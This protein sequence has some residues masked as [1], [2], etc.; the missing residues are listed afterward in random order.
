LG[1]LSREDI[2]RLQTAPEQRM[3]LSR[4]SPRHGWK[5]VPDRLQ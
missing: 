3:A 5:A 1:A 4:G 2:E